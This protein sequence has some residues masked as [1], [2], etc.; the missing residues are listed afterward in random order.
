MMRTRS[1]SSSLHERILQD[2]EQKILSGQWPPG[3]RIASEHELTET[4]QCSRMT[5]NKVL[6]QLARASR[7][8]TSRRM[9]IKST[10][11]KKQ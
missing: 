5:V 7:L 1:V 6:T 10:A 8:S 9:R 3:R 11:P 4:Y 2:I